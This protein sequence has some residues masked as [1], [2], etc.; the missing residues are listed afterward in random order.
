MN[1]GCVSDTNA[2]AFLQLLHN[3]W[4]NELTERQNPHST[5]FTNTWKVYKRLSRNWKRRCTIYCG[6][7]TVMC[8]CEKLSM[9]VVMVSGV[10][11][12]APCHHCF[13][14]NKILMRWRTVQRKF[15]FDRLLY[16]RTKPAPPP[17]LL[18]LPTYPPIS[19]TPA[20]D[21]DI[22]TNHLPSQHSLPSQHPLHGVSYEPY[23]RCVWSLYAFEIGCVA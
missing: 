1:T 22:K 8:V 11:S 7:Y 2:D 15:C 19:H 12:F 3:W 17:Y 9:S 5:S 13:N 16:K 14:Q 10:C 20:T 23:P 21:R 4:S 6:N 18:T